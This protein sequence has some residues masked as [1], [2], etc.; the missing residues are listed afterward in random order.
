MRKVSIITPCLNS[1]NTIRDTIESVLHQTYKA[2][3]YIIIDGGSADKTIE[4]IKE[5]I[6]LF[7]GRLTY[8]SEEDKGIYDA[9]NKGIK[10]SSGSLI[11]I[12]NSDD[13]YELDAVES[14]VKEMDK[15]PYQVLYGYCNFVRNNRVYAISKNSH[16]DLPQKMIPHPTC[17]VTREVFR[18]FGMFIRFYKISADYEFMLRLKKCGRVSFI[19]IPKVIANFRAGGASSSIKTNNLMRLEDNLIKYRYG[20]LT[21]RKACLAVWN[22]I[23]NK[24]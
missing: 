2:I 16:L 14:A 23:I 19:Q 17:F 4:I 8:I 12:I 21:G 1:Q 7:Q 10:M 5:Y 3:E 20:A 13:F 15:S 18:D 11:G 24:Y 9:M 6:P 22:Y